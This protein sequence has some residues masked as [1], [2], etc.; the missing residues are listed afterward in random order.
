MSFSSPIRKILPCLLL[1]CLGWSTV[2]LSAQ[3]PSLDSLLR[4]EK[5]YL[6]PDTTRANLL[7]DLARAHYGAS[8][9]RGLE[10]ADKAIAL[11][12]T[13]SDKKF[14]A[15]AHGVKGNFKMAQGEYTQALDCYNKALSLNQRLGNR[16]GMAN[17]LVNIG[18]VYYSMVQYP[19]ALEFYQQALTLY[20]KTGQDLGMANCL[21]NL[22]NIYNELRDYPQALAFYQRALH[23]SEKTGNATS[24]SGLLVNIGNVYTQLADYPKALEFKQRA[25]ALSEKSGNKPRIANNLSNIGNVYTQMADY[26]QALRFHQRALAI[27]ES[28]GDKKGMAANLAGI[29]SVYLLQ[30]DIPLAVEFARRARSL[31]RSQGLLNTEC[32]ALQNLSKLYEATGRFD[33]AFLAFQRFVVLRDSITNVDVQK[34]VTKKTLQYEFGKTQDSLRQQ[35]LLTDARLSRQRLAYLKTQAELQYEQSQNKIKADQLAM[36]ENAQ[37]LQSTQV[38]LQQTQLQL[39]GEAL[40]SQRRQRV[41]YLG[42]IALLALLSFFVFRNFINQQRSNRIIRLE[43]QKSDEL[44]RNILPDEVA[45]ELKAKGEAR[46]RQYEAVTVLFTDFVDFT[47]ASE[48][49]SPE[50]LVREL[51]TCFKAFDEIIERHGLEKIKTIGDAY[52]AVSGLPLPNDQHAQ[53][54]ARAALDIRQYIRQRQS[55]QPGSFEIRIGLSSGPV[56][57][58]IVGVKK[59]AYDIWGD[60]VNTAARMESASAPGRI[61]ISGATYAQLE[62]EF[63]CVHRGKVEAKHKGEVDM[64]FLEGESA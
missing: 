29:S 6:Q 21:G 5:T 41:Y 46:A 47:R 48:R 25:L 37:Q 16:P 50:Q 51:H 18:S 55:L 54:A 27:N 8:T 61:N 11:A 60:T 31:A 52:M 33:S 15:R 36:A 56:V 38:N 39:Q 13:L 49:Q 23:L 34:Q 28:I 44:L 45:D 20:E 14:L 1:A 63:R 57:A 19:R 12:E 10:F 35:Q 3:Q 7:I 26:P 40:Q 32:E 2:R 53:Q 62:G 22:G 58:G 43:K 42:T 59:F 4:R 64:Y 17:N 24:L 9:A 30:Q